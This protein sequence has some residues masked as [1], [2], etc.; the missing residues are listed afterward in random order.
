MKIRHMIGAAGFGICAT[1]WTVLGVGLIA[2][3]S[4]ATR[5]MMIVAAGV[6]VELLFWSLALTAGLT[7]YEARRTIWRRLTGGKPRE[8]Y[9]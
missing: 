7:V 2:G 4:G 9:S 6:S 1:A 3:V 5:A 8:E